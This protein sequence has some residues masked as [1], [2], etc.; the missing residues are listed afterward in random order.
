MA[1]FVKDIR[2]A[3]EEKCA[4]LN[5]PY[6]V[7]LGAGYAAFESDGDTMQKCIQRADNNLYADKGVKRN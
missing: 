1:N 3:V 4:E 6:V 7:S 2:K 5:K